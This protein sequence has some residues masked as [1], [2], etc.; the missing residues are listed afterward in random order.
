MTRVG[1]YL[2]TA[3]LVCGCTAPPVREDAHLAQPKAAEMLPSPC[4][5]PAHLVRDLTVPWSMRT[6]VIGPCPTRELPAA[7]TVPTTPASSDIELSAS[8]RATP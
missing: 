4:H 2:L 8:E 3:L 6:Y 5:A 7:S 1:V